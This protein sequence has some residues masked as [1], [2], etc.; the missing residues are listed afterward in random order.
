MTSPIN[1]QLLKDAIAALTIPELWKRL[2]IP[3]NPKIGDNKSPLRDDD[4]N[5]SFSIYAGGHRAKDHGTGWDGDSYNFYQDYLKQS[6]KEAYL[7]FIHLAGLGHRLNGDNGKIGRGSKKIPPF[8]WNQCVSQPTESQLGVLA[9]WRGFGIPYC[10]SLARDKLLGRYQDRWAFPVTDSEGNIIG[11]HYLANPEK[12]LWLFN[13]KGTKAWPLVLGQLQKCSEIH[14]LES[15][16]DGLGL[17]EHFYPGDIA[18]V[19][20]RGA[21]NFS[22]IG[23][24]DIPPNVDVYVWPQNDQAKANGTIPGESWFEGVKK[25]LAR[26]FYRVLTPTKY[27]DLNEWTQQGAA[28][29]HLRQAIDDAGLVMV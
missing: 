16:W 5:A 18:V 25:E 6:S 29:E 19:I 12:K 22:K 8:D 13:P 9:S 2:G 24:L 3:G 10:Q 27:A 4:R 26:D 20:T 7:P 28:F 14:I 15:T 23:S 17:Y 21:Q 1:H 11:C